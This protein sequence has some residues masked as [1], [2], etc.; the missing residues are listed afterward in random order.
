M[1][2]YEE[3]KRLKTQLER[4]YGAMHSDMDE[5]EKFYDLDFGRD[6]QTLEGVEAHIPSTA[7]SLVEAA[8]SQ[9]RTDTP[10]VTVIPPGPSAEAERLAQKQ[11]RF[12]QSMLDRLQ[13]AYDMP[14]PNQI[15]FDMVLLGAAAVKLVYDKD[16]LPEEPKQGTMDEVEFAAAMRTWQAQRDFTFPFYCVPVDPRNL[17]LPPNT[18]FPYDYSIE[19]QKSTLIDVRL[20]YPMWTDPKATGRM[21]KDK[22][23]NPLREVEICEYWDSKRNQIYVDGQLVRDMPNPRG[24]TPYVWTYSGLGSKR[25]GSPPQEAAQGI[26]SKC[27]SELRSE[28]QLKTALDTLWRFHAYPRV[29]TQEDPKKV[30][31]DL[32][33]GPSA[34]IEYHTDRPPEYMKPP[35]PNTSMWAFL[36][37]LQRSISS[38]TLSDVLS[39]DRM[40]GTSGGYMQSLLIG[41]A[42]LKFGPV[43]HALEKCLIRCIQLFAMQIRATGHEMSVHGYDGEKAEPPRKIKPTDLQGYIDFEVSLDSGD[44]SEDLNRV[45]ALLSVV[46]AK[47]MSVRSYIKMALG[48][49]PDEESAQISAETVLQQVIAQGGLVPEAMQAALTEQ[50][51]AE[52]GAQI[53]EGKRRVN[54]SLGNPGA[55]EGVPRLGLSASPAGNPD[56]APRLR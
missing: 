17:L 36:P 53:A 15:L 39:G 30:A 5:M 43:K 33:A 45:T 14:I 38:S 52:T 19:T 29:V 4:H 3:I 41:Q 54:N 49:D 23:E 48:L 20:R 26:L 37:E 22:R 28:A 9:L 1:P 18:K 44:P 32:A 8:R 40:P 7:S 55:R 21:S 10:N 16:A 50:Q 31:A 56:T 2:N 42:R 46:Q 6:I 51:I 24:V 27:I 13:D 11:Q 25:L 47:G 34:V 12:G 35:D